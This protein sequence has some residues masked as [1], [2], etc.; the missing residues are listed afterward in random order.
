MDNWEVDIHPV[1]TEEFEA[2]SEEVQDTLLARV[3]L[4]EKYVPRLKR[5]NADTLYDSKYS[6]M[7]ELRLEAGN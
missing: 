6:N 5:P 2:L 7:K 3:E 1:F 4:L